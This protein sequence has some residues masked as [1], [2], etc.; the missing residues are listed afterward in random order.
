VLG[1][2]PPLMGFFHDSRRRAGSELSFTQVR[3][4]GY[5]N[6]RPGVSLSALNESLGVSLPATSRQI[7]FLVR[8][9]WVQREA[10][11]RDRRAIR[12][13][14]TPAG[15]ERLLEA[16]HQS[17]EELARVFRRLSP[18]ERGTIVEAMGHI[19]RLFEELPVPGVDEADCPE[20][21]S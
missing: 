1:A 18:A 19:Q 2:I 6:R 12:L 17:A 14:L 10:S 9:G 13:A 5:L 21:R 15:Q 11:Q 7:E 16:R 20:T 8:Q 3:M 4:L